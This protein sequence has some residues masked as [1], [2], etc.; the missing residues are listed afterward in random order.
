VSVGFTL[1]LKLILHCR[2]KTQVRNVS[3]SLK[4][5]IYVISLIIEILEYGGHID[6]VFTDFEKAFDKV[7]HKRLINELASYTV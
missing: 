7:L 4:V 2:Y 5:Q 1:A 3:N 6:V